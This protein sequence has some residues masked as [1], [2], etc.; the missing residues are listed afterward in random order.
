MYIV[1]VWYIIGIDNISVYVEKIPVT[2]PSLFGCIILLYY[3]II[4]SYEII[5]LPPTDTRVNV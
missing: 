4:I 5:Y 1:Y 3:I 2:I